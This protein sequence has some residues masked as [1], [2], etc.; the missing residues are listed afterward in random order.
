[1]PRNQSFIIETL[2]EENILG[3][4]FKDGTDHKYDMMSHEEFPWF[5]S[6]NSYKISDNEALEILVLDTDY[7]EFLNQYPGMSL[8]KLIE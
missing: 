8:D 3:Y 1:M 4:E 5:G 2:K 6:I 7:G